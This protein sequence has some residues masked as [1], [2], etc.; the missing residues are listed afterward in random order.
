MLFVKKIAARLTTAPAIFH[1]LLISQLII[2]LILLFR[3]FMLTPPGHVYTI[4]ER[5]FFYPNLILQGKDGAWK[6][7]DTHTT[8]FS[9]HIF[10]YTFFILLGKLAA[11]GRFEPVWVYVWARIFMGIFVFYAT[12]WLIYTLLPKAVRSLAILLALGI[13]TGPILSELP[14]YTTLIEQ[15]IMILRH[16]DLPHHLFAEATGIIFVGF[17]LLSAQK[18]TARR[19]VTMTLA[20][21]LS[22]VT[23]PS[24]TFTF[25]LCA[26]PSW[27][28]WSVLHKN[29][30][31]L[32][33]VL[34][35]A[36]AAIILPNLIFAVE[37]AKG[38]PWTNSTP[39]EKTWHTTPFIRTEYISQ[40]LFYVPF[41]IL[42]LL[43]L[44]YMWRTWDSF[45]KQVI[46]L[47]ASWLI[48]PMLW[49]AAAKT[50]WFPMPNRRLTDGYQFLPAGILAAVTIHFIMTRFSKKELRNIVGIFLLAI[51]FIPSLFFTQYFTK[52][53]FVAQE[54]S[55]I[56][57]YP[58][59]EVWDG[60][61]FT[62][63]FP[64]GSGILIREQFGESIPAFADVRVYVGGIHNYPDWLDRQ[65]Q[66]AHFFSGRMTDEEAGI[67]LKNSDISYVFYG[68]DE[69][70]V[71]ETGDLYPNILQSI[72]SNSDVTIFRIKNSQ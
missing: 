60:I 15:R 13:E 67:F 5:N 35:V 17:L 64:R 1:I 20:G 38:P 72:F 29:F 11:I 46:I 63:T 3:P 33:P 31:K 55:D 28:I 39:N 56:H 54:T 9:P 69:K 14:R 59:R 68:P 58:T 71:N 34:A 70:T 12:L 62:K 7:L 40:L 44:P 26:F 42:F 65:A 30:R 37:F 45:R 47:M 24:Y 19:I 6:I 27:V 49:V 50:D 43:L 57:I 53:L 16:F 66:A 21:I 18:L 23:M 36:C 41:I 61:M 4:I 51:V 8:L 52:N 2:I 25:A 22:T 32:L 10:A 48:G